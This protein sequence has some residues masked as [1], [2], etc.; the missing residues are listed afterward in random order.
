MT[1]FFPN[2]GR[3]LTFERVAWRS[4]PFLVTRSLSARSMLWKPWVVFLFSAPTRQAGN[5]VFLG[6]GCPGAS[7]YG[8]NL[9]KN[10]W[11]C[12]FDAW[13]NQNILGGRRKTHIG[14]TKHIYW[15]ERR[16]VK[17]CWRFI[18]FFTW[19]EGGASAEIV[20]EERE[21][22]HTVS[23]FWFAGNPQRAI[24]NPSKPEHHDF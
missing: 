23:C 13:K 11:I 15:G 8:S 10:T 20:L 22:N 12:L 16:W 2:V 21:P 17:V 7:I 18:L 4:R 3:H 9:P 14:E 1:F 24:T 19:G 6:T 5:D